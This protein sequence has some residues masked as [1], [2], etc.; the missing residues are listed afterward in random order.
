MPLPKFQT[1]EHLAA[2]AR[3]AIFAARLAGL[4]VAAGML[5][6]VMASAAPPATGSLTRTVDVAASADAVW[7]AIGGFCAIKDWHPAIATCSEIH[8]PTVRTL[9]TKDGSATFV[10]PETA[11]N[12]AKRQYSY[13]FAAAPIPVSHYNA[14]ISVTPKKSGATVTWHGTWTPEPGKE[15][16]AMDALTGIYESGL[17]ALKV[18]FAK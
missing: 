13:T 17:D 2:P 16:A 9:V 1:S 18:K 12:D 4:L 10:E 3:K 8:A 6:P 15:K 7:S 14:T 11:R 5:V